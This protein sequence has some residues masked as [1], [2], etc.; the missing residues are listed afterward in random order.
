MKLAEIKPDM[1]VIWTRKLRGGYGYVER[2]L[3]IVQKVG[4][5]RVTI[6]APLKHG[7]TKHVSVTPDR[8]ELAASEN[9]DPCDAPGA[10]ASSKSAAPPTVERPST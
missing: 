1:P 9:P 6:E 2:V 7:G 4:A 8:L 3:A 10:A 5:A